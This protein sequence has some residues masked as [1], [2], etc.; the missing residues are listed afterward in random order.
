MMLFLLCQ[1]RLSE[2]KK[3]PAFE[4]PCFLRRENITLERSGGPNPILRGIFLLVG[5]VCARERAS[6]W[7]S[8]WPWRR[9]GWCWRWER[10]VGT[11]D[12]T[13]TE[14][15]IVRALGQD[16]PSHSKKILWGAL[17]RLGTVQNEGMEE[18]RH[19]RGENGKDKWPQM[20]S[21]ILEPGGTERCR[22]TYSKLVF[23][24][25]S[26]KNAYPSLPK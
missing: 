2:W 17:L 22:S 14:K 3:S 18:S 4:R 25:S 12:M 13:S 26:L 5:Y 10:Y 24:Q 16:P 9:N 1:V 23:N 7:V 8:G 11:N 15:E 19:V 21:P 20:M 6:D